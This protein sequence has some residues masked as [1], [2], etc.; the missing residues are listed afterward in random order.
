[1]AY[2][3]I[4][5][6]AVLD[7]Q[8]RACEDTGMTIRQVPTR[9]RH[10]GR[11]LE[12]ILG[13]PKLPESPQQTNEPANQQETALKVTVEEIPI[14][15]IAPN[16]YQPRRNWDQTKLAQLAES[17]KTNGLLQPV[18]VRRT[19][20]GYQLI[21]GERR[22]RAFQLLGMT[23]IPAIVRQTDETQQLEWSLLENIQRDDLN[24][25]DRARAYQAYLRATGYTQS[26]A[27]RRLG[28]DD[29]VISNYLRLL[30][31][32]Q[33]IQ[34]MLIDGLLS[35]GHAR[36]ILGLPTDELR[37]KLANKTV[38]GRLSVREVERLVR[39]WV[40][41]LQPN[42]RQTSPMRPHIAELEARIG[43]ALGTKVR[44]DVHRNGRQGRLT[45]VFQSLEDFDRILQILGIQTD[46]NVATQSSL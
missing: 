14:Q 1:M 8:G 32:P 43:S 6:A 13:M 33:E 5:I 17:I 10:L 22:L 28:E 12:A 2:D 3:R 19:A 27:A 15:A 42:A 31:L 34:Q 44:I 38:A 20:V 35:M 45:I 37:R 40:S 24:P 39:R 30:D 18:L 25:I 29:S 26:E 36:A 41:E 16:P 7:R 9:T 21:A 4:H 46:E 23:T 11:G